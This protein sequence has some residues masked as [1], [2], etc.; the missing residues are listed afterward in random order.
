MLAEN[1]EK[2]ANAKIAEEQ[3]FAEEPRGTPTGG[4]TIDHIVPVCGYALKREGGAGK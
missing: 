4:L 1:A 2:S 3:R